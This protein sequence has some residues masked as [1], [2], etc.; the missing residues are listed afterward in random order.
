[1]ESLR[2][3]TRRFAPAQDEDAFFVQSTIPF[4]LSRDASLDAAERRSG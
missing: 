1:M 3:S 2:P 4:I